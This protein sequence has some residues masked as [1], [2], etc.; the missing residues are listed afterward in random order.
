M[1]CGMNDAKELSAGLL[2]LFDKTSFDD[3]VAVGND[4]NLIGLHDQ[5]I[6]GKQVLNALKLVS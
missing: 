5:F 2:D 3:R 1:A 6:I 4:K